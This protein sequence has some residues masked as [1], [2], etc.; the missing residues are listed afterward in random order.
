MNSIKV[1]FSTTTKDY[2]THRVFTQKKPTLIQTTLFRIIPP[3]NT[4][5]KKQNIDCS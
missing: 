1:Y 3:I 5:Q 2:T 4:R